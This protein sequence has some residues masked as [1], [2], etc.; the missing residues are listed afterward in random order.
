MTDATYPWQGGT[1][2]MLDDMALRALGLDQNQIVDTI[3]Q[4][5]HAQ[6][7]GQIW[8]SPKATLTPGDQRYMMTTLSASDTP[9][10]SV[11]KVVSVSPKNPAA[12]RPAIN[13]SIMLHDSQNGM[14]VAVLD[15]NWITAV[16]TAGLSGVVARKLANPGSTSVAFVG[17]GVQARSHLDCFAALFPLTR[18]SIFGRGQKNIDRLS[19]HARQMG[20][21]VDVCDT[22]QAVVSDADLVVTSVTVTTLEEAF[23]DAGWLKPGAFATIT[24]TGAPWRQETLGALDRIVIDD[25]AQETAMKKKMVPPDLVTTDLNGLVGGALPDGFVPQSRTAFVFRGIAIGDFA[26]AALA[27]QRALNN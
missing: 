11:V 1:I 9:A 19:A 23:L 25:I 22:A 14:L 12:G 15:A 7:D 24:D 20:L 4:A 10:V 17:A 18:I 13:G 16:R 21:Q 26:I 8:T 27:Y 5:L 2:Q 3:E 6:A